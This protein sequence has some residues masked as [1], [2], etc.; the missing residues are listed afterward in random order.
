MLVEM[1]ALQYFVDFPIGEEG[2]LHLS[3]NEAEDLMMEDIGVFE[4]DS[5]RT[6]VQARK[7]FIESV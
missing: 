7:L 6:C 3:H 2:E 5:W 1:V 4:F